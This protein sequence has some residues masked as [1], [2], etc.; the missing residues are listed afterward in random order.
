MY[1]KDNITGQVRPYGTNCHD[2]LMISE[3]GKYLTYYNLQCGEG[4]EYGS[5]SFVTDKAGTL[6][7]D[8]EDLI[9]HGAEVFNIG[10]WSPINLLK[11]LREDIAKE[12][13]LAYADFD[14]Y[15]EN[16]LETEADDLPDDDFRYGM[17][18]CMVIINN[19]INHLKK[20]GM[21]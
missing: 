4:S 13:E 7:K 15:K 8:D 17:E 21:T 16:V 11:E 3:D 2:S 5:Y 20:E 12:A 9:K 10:G 6:P 18:R 1:I 14:A 19:T